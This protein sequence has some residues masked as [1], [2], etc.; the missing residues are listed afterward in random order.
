MTISLWR[1]SH[2][3]LAISSAIFLCLASITGV[4]LAFEPIANATKPYAIDD[5][6]N[7]TIAETIDVLQK[8]YKDIIA[9]NVEESNF[10]VAT[11]VTHLGK[12]KR[13][14]VDPRTGEELGEPRNK[15][16]VFEFATNL[17]RSLF[18]KSLGR[19]FVGLISFLLVIIVITGILLILKRQGGI[20]RFF[21]KINKE[22]SNQYY[23]IVL[24]RWFLIPILIIAVT[25]VY[26]SLEKFS[27]LPKHSFSNQ[28]NF[29]KSQ[30]SSVIAIVDFPV[31]KNTSLKEVKNID[32]PFSEDVEDYFTVA[33]INKELLVH[34]FSGVVLS[35]Q[36]YPF[37]KIVSYYSLLLHTGR[38]NVL[39]SIIL[40]ISCGSM[41]FFMYSGFYMTVKRQS[42][43][44]LVYNNENK[45]SCEY[46]ILVGSENGS[47]FTFANLL[48]NVISAVNKT[49]FISEL[50]SYTT[51]QQAKQII[52][53][54]A[55]Y[56]EGEA[57]TNAKKFMHLFKKIQP[58]NELQF[59]VVGLG[60]RAYPDFCKYAEDIEEILESHS[61]FTSILPL[62]KIN[63]KAIDE[64]Q[65]WMK[66]WGNAIGLPIT[67]ETLEET[68]K[69]DYEDFTVVDRTAVNSDNTFLL[70][71]QPLKSSMKFCSGDLLA[72][73]PNENTVDRLYSIGKVDG[74]I[75]LSIKRHEMGV[76]S[77]YL[78]QLHQG[79]VINARIKRNEA[80]YFP[81]SANTVVLIANGTGVA[82][83]LGMIE[84][85]SKHSNA[86]L[87]WGVRT[88]K[89]LAIYDGFIKS[90]IVKSQFSDGYI[91]YSQENDCV[92]IQ[93]IVANK[94]N[95]I[96][97]TL[98]KDGVI[99]ICGSTNMQKAVLSVL[100]NIT[101][102]KLKTPLQIFHNNEQ[103]RMDCY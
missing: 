40:L 15:S 64:F 60:S 91:A 67:T 10:V 53:I 6:E 28:A 84:N 96:A 55:T 39:W 46:V 61:K 25:G 86:H 102:D 47:T 101:E 36:Q 48:K 103:I 74:T 31:F 69:L 65:E 11:V 79:D 63:N 42:E 3:I 77:S 90:D 34:Q 27:L 80:F 78:E 68:E 24:G 51:F 56:G 41:L 66:K 87:F 30:T 43:S 12:S 18:L 100:E 75:L 72:I 54:T 17:H 35:E 82:P 38:G 37:V 29:D 23:H 99:M 59:S 1:Y 45:D 58:I 32:F 98:Q 19:F 85:K 94:A 33:L 89:S 4:I 13:I 70:R 21:S 49:V 57:P 9:I 92:Y 2:L 8:E 14:Y 95:F 50:N 22:Y 97:E 7:I 83:F 76:C 73:R 44:K 52:V 20:S 88:K 5:I 81:S 16:N 62:Q 26:L 71:L 93:N